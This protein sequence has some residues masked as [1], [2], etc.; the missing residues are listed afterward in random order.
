[1]DHDIRA[2]IEQKN[3]DKY[4]K[5]DVY[6]ASTICRKNNITSNEYFDVLL[7]EKLKLVRI[8]GKG[9]KVLDVCCGSGEH[10]FEVS[11][12]INKGTGLD[13][14][15]SNVRYANGL[16]KQNDY[17]N[18]DFIQGN[19]KKMNL[20][21]NL[22]DLVYCYSSLYYIPFV[23]DMICEIAR[24]VSRNGYCILDMGN[25]FSLN[26]IVCQAYPELANPCHISVPMMKKH[27]INS[28]L[29][30]VEHRSFQILPF[31]GERPN[32]AKFLLASWYRNLLQKQIRGKMMDERISSLPLV[33]Y[34]AFRHLFIC[35]K[36]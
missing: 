27:I 18:L 33:N 25:K 35:K 21:D 36:L 26:T 4:S 10:L 12:D 7:R 5:S 34:F 9:K 1:M 22:Y 31:W 19:A 14:S 6:A 11:D 30:I 2:D 8:Y 15:C 17:G 29:A 23:Q 20:P 13:Y 16:K 28:G 3:L 32:W 24:V